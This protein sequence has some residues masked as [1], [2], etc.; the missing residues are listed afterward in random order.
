MLFG[1]LFG[2]WPKDNPPLF[3][4]ASV[5]TPKIYFICID[6]KAKTVIYRQIA[7]ENILINRLFLVLLP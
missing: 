1:S 6:E 3:F 5:I 7:N 2:L 4:K